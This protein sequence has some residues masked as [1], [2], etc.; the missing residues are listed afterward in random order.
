MML[1]VG[2]C[3]RVMRERLAPKSI[4]LIVTSPPYFNARSYSSYATY[5]DYL[6]ML[7]AFLQCAAAVLKPGRILAINLSCV[8]EPRLSRN[9]ESTRLPIPFDFAPLAR[10]RGFK[11]LDDIIWE[12][13]DGAS[14]RAIKFSHHRRPVAYKTFNVTEYILIFKNGI[15]GLLDKVIRAHDTETIAASLI[16]DDYER[17]NVWK[18]APSHSAQHPATFPVTLAEKLIRYYSFVGDVVLD[19]FMG[20][21][22]TGVAAKALNREFIGIDTNPEYVELARVRITA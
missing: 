18:I 4:D 13:P 15:A 8:L 9:Y 5:A 19:P 21:G 12:K 1:Y 2:D 17:T 10:E 22:T 16:G 20:L 14:S 3:L 6:E 7:D 11:F